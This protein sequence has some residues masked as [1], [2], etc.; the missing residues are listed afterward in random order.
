MPVQRTLISPP[1]CRMGALIPEERATVRARSPVGVKYDASINRDSA[2]EM[3]TR[4][5]QARAASAEEPPRAPTEVQGARGGKLGELL[6][7]TKRRQGIVETLAKQ[8]A[9]TVGGQLGRQ[10]LRGALGGIL[11][12]SRRR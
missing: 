7:G 4:R 8:A 5:A 1:R 10:I 9:R 12:T 11:G 2:R 6:S 3:L